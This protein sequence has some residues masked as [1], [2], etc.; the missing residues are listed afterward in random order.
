MT[1]VNIEFH[2]FLVFYLLVGYDNGVLPHGRVQHGLADAVEGFGNAA[3][4]LYE[5]RICHV[6]G[7]LPVHSVVHH[8]VLLL[9]RH[10]ALQCHSDHHLV[11]DAFVLICVAC[12]DDHLRICLH[13][14]VADSR[15]GDLRLWIVLLNVQADLGSRE[16]FLLFFS[17]LIVFDVD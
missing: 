11:A 12:G 2:L 1:M 8:L 6:L 5:I 10:L 15:V 13:L 3:F 9:L 16:R 7:A 14:V 4:F 17:V